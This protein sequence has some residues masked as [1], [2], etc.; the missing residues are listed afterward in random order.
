MKIQAEYKNAG[1]QVDLVT[2]DYKSLFVTQSGKYQQAALDGR[3]FF[4]YCAARAT[5]V[6]ATAQ[7][8]NIIYNPS[9]SGVNLIMAKW[10]AQI[11]VTSAT[12]LGF[13]FGTSA[14]L[15]T[16]TTTTVADAYGCTL[17]NPPGF[18][19]GQAIAYA[20]ATIVTAPAPVFLMGHNTAAIN[21]VG[22]DHI[23]GDFDGMF[24]VPPGN[25]VAIS[26]ITAAVAA[27]GMTSTLTW[28][29][30]PV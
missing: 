28:I 22:V 25:V 11:Q 30:E 27:A 20:I 8:G 29:E 6:P 19:K 5:S 23:E 9:T 24:I 17:L 2:D 12:T 16:P 3:M 13:T 14:Q 15:T 21:T 26:A 1:T 10:N 4:S 18:T 7:I